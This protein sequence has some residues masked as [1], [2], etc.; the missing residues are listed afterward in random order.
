MT[1][2]QVESKM[3][4]V[5][6]KLKNVDDTADILAIVEHKDREAKEEME[7]KI[8]KKV[9]NINSQIRNIYDKHLIEPGYWGPA[10]AEKYP[11]MK[12]YL[13]GKVAMTDNS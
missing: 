1:L 12:A 10:E 5:D 7:D 13:L 8:E 9:E 6:E 2:M 4:D 3:D 11:T